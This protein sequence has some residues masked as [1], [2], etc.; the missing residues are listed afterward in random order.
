MLFLLFY[1][2]DEIIYVCNK[3]FIIY[4]VEMTTLPF[5]IISGRFLG[6]SRGGLVCVAG[7]GSRGRSSAQVLQLLDEEGQGQGGAAEGGCGAKLSCASVG[8]ANFPGQCSAMELCKFPPIFI[9]IHSFNVAACD[10][11]QADS[12]PQQRAS[13][14][15]QH[16]KT[17]V[18]KI[19]DLALK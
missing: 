14:L 6:G 1:V 8:Y 11:E 2:I 7:S 5:S 3:H 12:A 9:C 13:W 19:L 10:C 17:M 16:V 4:T 18:M 15:L